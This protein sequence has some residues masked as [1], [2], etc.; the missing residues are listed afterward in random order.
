MVPA[1]PE[2][3]EPPPS[4]E[5]V[6]RIFDGLFAPRLDTILRGGAAEPLYEPGRPNVLRYREDYVAS[7]LHEVAH[8]CVAGPARRALVDFGYWY[9][10]DGRS[11]DQ[12]DLFERVEVKPQAME[13]LF[14]EACGWG[15]VLSA[16][17]VDGD[18]GPSAAFAEAVQ[19]QRAAYLRDGLPRRADRFREALQALHPDRR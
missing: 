10:P 15:F 7:A 2:S 5:D 8:W 11:R 9:E 6:E 18:C 12:Q 16:D 14:A 1:Q 4:S 17:N 19:A 3:R 13:W